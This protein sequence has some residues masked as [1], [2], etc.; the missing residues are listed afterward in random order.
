MRGVVIFSHVGGGALVSTLLLAA[1]VLLPVVPLSDAAL[2]VANTRGNNE[3]TLISD[4][5]TASTFYD[6]TGLSAP[7]N[8]RLLDGYYYISTGTEIEDSSIARIDSATG[9]IDLTFAAGGGLK[10]PYGFDFYEDKLY[11][12]SFMTDEILVYDASTGDFMEVFAQGNATEEGLVNGPNQIAIH[13]G[14]LYMTTQGSYI[15]GNGTLQYA[16]ASQVVAFDL[17]TGEGSVFAP[18]PEVTS[19]GY[20]SMLGIMIGCDDQ[21]VV[22]DDCTVYTTDFAGGLRL[23]ALATGELLDFQDTTFVDGSITGSLTMSSTSRTLYVTGASA[24]DNGVI[25]TFDPDDVGGNLTVIFGPEGG[26]SRPIGI[27]YIDE[28]GDAITESPQ[29][30]P[31]SDDEEEGGEGS[32]TPPSESHAIQAA[33]HWFLVALLCVFLH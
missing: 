5:G 3:I 27:L 30:P 7:D 19:A 22:P 20:I 13:D 14:T 1:A 24:D 28:A 26:L 29:E 15:D 31:A 32:T 21:S 23:Y 33:W 9:E 18:P 6:G 2:L 12:A 10:R 16:F 17:M 8:I 25:M 11:V 4:N